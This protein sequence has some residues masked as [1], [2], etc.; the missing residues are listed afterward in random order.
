MFVALLRERSGSPCFSTAARAIVNNCM[1]QTEDRFG[2]LLDRAG[3]I[4]FWFIDPECPELS[5]RHFQQVI[6]TH[7]H[8]ELRISVIKCVRTGM[9]KNGGG[10]M[11]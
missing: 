4:M 1:N 10:Y 6:C 8:R 5:D 7:D 3:A 11:Y 9:I 2:I